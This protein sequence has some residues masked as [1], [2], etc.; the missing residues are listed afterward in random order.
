MELLADIGL[1]WLTTFLMWI[2]TVL[3]VTIVMVSAALMYLS[4]KAKRPAT[5][6][7]G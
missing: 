2:R 7:D 6:Q 5:E 3:V 1:L 4:Y